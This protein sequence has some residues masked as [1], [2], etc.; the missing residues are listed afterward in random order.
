[1]T[2]EQMKN[3][4]T[5]FIKKTEISR[6]DFLWMM[7]AASAGLVMGCATNPVTGRSQLMLVSETSEIQMDQKHSPHQFS[8]DYGILQDKPL[9]DYIDQTGQAIAAITH[10]PQMPYSFQGVNATYINAYAFPGG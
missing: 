2:G 7:S 1:M 4:D 3:I 6:R 9:N 10:R 5:P 8:T